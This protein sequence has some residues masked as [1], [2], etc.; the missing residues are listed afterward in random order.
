M[1][2]FQFKL[3]RLLEIRRDREEE[4]K[5][6]LAKASG[7]YQKE[8]MRKQGVLDNVENFRKELKQTAHMSLS[9]LQ[10]YDLL[11]QKSDAAIVEI[12]KEIERRKR[13]MEKEME[14]Y[15]KMKQDRRAVEL[16]K[17]KAY[18]QY[19]EDANKEEIAVLDEIG[20]NSFLNNKDELKNSDN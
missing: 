18:K 13:V 6:V 19:Q 17:E 4:Q 3:Q 15:V 1:K 5:I 2:K 10:A 14:I 7:E 9:Q 20:R 8:V 16:L 11:L 12:D